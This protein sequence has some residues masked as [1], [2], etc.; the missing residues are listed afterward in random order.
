[1][2]TEQTRARLG[3][4][5]QEF[6]KELGVSIDLVNS[7]AI[8]RRK[9]KDTVMKLMV[10]LIQQAYNMDRKKTPVTITEPQLV[11]GVGRRILG[12]AALAPCVRARGWT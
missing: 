5:R 11:F 9:P 6:A 7:W 3:M 10:M 1:M 2:N 12:K 4:S 8:G